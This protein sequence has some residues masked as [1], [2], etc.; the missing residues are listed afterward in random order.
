NHATDVGTALEPV[1]GITCQSK[2]LRSLANVRRQEPRALE[3]NVGRRVVDLAVLAA[4]DTGQSDDTLGVGDHQHLAGQLMLT[5]VNCR[6]A[7]AFPGTTN[8][9][10]GLSGWGSIRVASTGRSGWRA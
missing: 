9:D 10:H 7:L 8:N 2:L 6:E 1:T 5:V 3:Q 4:H